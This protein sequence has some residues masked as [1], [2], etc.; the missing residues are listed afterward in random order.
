M[1]D[2]FYLLQDGNIDEQISSSWWYMVSVLRIAMGLGRPPCL[3]HQ[4]LQDPGN[5]PLLFV[6]TSQEEWMGMLSESSSST[7]LL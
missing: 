1:Q 4:C 3:C 5:L 2:Y 7:N 6:V